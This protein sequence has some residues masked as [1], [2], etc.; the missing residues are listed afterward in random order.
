MFV[1]VGMF[2]WPIVLLCVALG[3]F[4]TLRRMDLI[5]QTV[6]RTLPAYLITVAM[7]FGTEALKQALARTGTGIGAIAGGVLLLS[8]LS[9][10][11]AIYFEIIAVQL[12]G[13]YYHHFKDRFAWS[14]G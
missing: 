6:F 4:S 8:F 1:C 9:T 3:G 14:W 2:F 7:V 12:I 11:I 5:V 13:L 10:G